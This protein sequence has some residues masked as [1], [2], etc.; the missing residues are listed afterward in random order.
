MDGVRN[1]VSPI[2]SSDCSH[3]KILSTENS[4][5]KSKSS[6]PRNSTQQSC[7]DTVEVCERENERSPTDGHMEI[8]EKDVFRVSVE[9]NNQKGSNETSAERQG[10]Q[11]LSFRRMLSDFGKD[12][13]AHGIGRITEGTTRVSRTV[14]LL[15]VT[16]AACMM[17]YQMI[18]LLLTYFE[19]NVTVQVSL[20]SE[21]TLEFPTVTVCNTNKLRKSAVRNSVYNQM[22]ILENN[23]VPAYYVPCLEG[24]FL[25]NNGIHCIKLYLV[26]DGINHCGDMSDEHHCSYPECGDDQFRCDSGSELGMCISNDLLCDKTTHCYGGE[27]EDNC[28]ECEDP[29]FRCLVSSECINK[30]KVC[31][32]SY[33]CRDGSDESGSICNP[34]WRNVAKGKPAQQSGRIYRNTRPILAVDGN[35]LTCA[36]TQNMWQPFW[37]VNLRKSYL[38]YEL[39]ITHRATTNPRLAGAQIRIGMSPRMFDNP[40]CVERIQEYQTQ[41]KNFTLRC[42][43]SPAAGRFVFIKILG[44][45]EAMRLCEVE[46]LAVDSRHWNLASD[47]LASQS[48]I[49]AYG[50]AIKAIDGDKTNDY[51]GRS[52]TQTQKEHQPW[53]KV[54]LGREFEIHDVIITNRGDCCGDRLEGAVVRVGNDE[55]IANNQKCEESIDT[56]GIN[57]EGEISIQCLLEGRFVSIQLENK[58]DYLTLCEVEIMGQEIASKLLN[59]AYGKPAEQSSTY[60]RNI[61]S[62]AVD[63][64]ENSHLMTGHSCIHSANEAGAWWRVDLLKVYSVYKVVIIN[65]NDCCASQLIGAIVRIGYYR[66]DFEEDSPCGGHVTETDTNDVTIERDCMVPILGRYVVL[67]NDVTRVGYLHVCEVKV[68]AKE[69]EIDDY[70]DIMKRRLFSMFDKQ[71]DRTIGVNATDILPKVPLYKCLE[72]CFHWKLYSCRSFDYHRATHTCRLYN[73]S[74]GYDDA[75][76]V[77]AP[78]TDYYQSLRTPLFIPPNEETDC[79]LYYVRCTSGECVHPYQICDTVVDCV[80]GFDESACLNS[81]ERSSETIFE[82]GWQA[83]YQSIS[84]DPNIYN[85]FKEKIFIRRNYDRVKG[86]SPPDWLRFKSFSS[87]PD[88]MDLRDVLRVDKDEVATMGHQAEDF[89]LQCTYAGEIC[90]ARNDFVMTQ[91]EYYGNCFHF[92]AKPDSAA[93]YSRGAGIL[94][95]LSLILFTEQNEY[96]SIYGQDSASVVSIVP[97]NV[98]PFPGQSGFFAMPGTVT[99]VS[100]TEILIDRLSKPYGNCTED[101]SH[102]QL[103]LGI[104]KPSTK[105]KYSL[106]ACETACYRRSL[107]HYCGCSDSLA[108]KI[109]PCRITNET[110]EICLQLIRFFFYSDLLPCNCPPPCR[111]TKYQLTISQS[112]WPS[113]AYLNNLLKLVKV[114]NPKTRNLND[115]ESAR[116]NLIR[117]N[118]YFESLNIQST[119]QLPAYKWEDLLSDV[120][121][122]FGLYIGLS[123][124]TL[125]EIIQFFISL[126]SMLSRSMTVF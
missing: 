10:G 45:S 25:C 83:P 106:L 86:E 58:T 76:V 24:D 44:K 103:P 2:A 74:V 6:R 53:W 95:G 67:R 64:N 118:V 117:L 100:M 85:Y 90:D 91:D 112:K 98:S 22:L 119:S 80:D 124:I 34:E 89:I 20:M 116:S 120:G 9:D 30:L 32:G 69:F 19:Y 12:T 92:N 27:D 23:F 50:S 66:D 42:N 78:G 109:P 62:R 82:A 87:T 88:Y 65:R 99:S 110:Q 46:V 57:L 26:C 68:F 17:V 41:T 75:E 13:T 31:D 115:L 104:K 102:I 93:I 96:L 33:D 97:R 14:W 36:L 11:D 43:P 55:D 94:H 49:Y 38:V 3:D 29:H 73:E 70:K 84:D 60:Y 108:I 61:A 51:S 113:D 121:G 28:D 79:P 4:M 7:L 111:E 39:R 52:C 71:V 21:K 125:F 77:K 16:I 101:T 122:T 35:V 126:C 54:D 1:K 15:I 56:V 107:L 81:S 48:S 123:L 114:K 37:T 5:K 8:T 105:L 63:G 72:N 18:Y 47:K 59:V 40:I